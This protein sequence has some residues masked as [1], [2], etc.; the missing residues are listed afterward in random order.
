MAERRRSATALVRITWPVLLAGALAHGCVVQGRSSS[1][2][3][4]NGAGGAASGFAV[5]SSSTSGPKADVGGGDSGPSCGDGICDPDEDCQSC[6][7]D[8]ATG[9]ADADATALDSEELAFLVI[10]NDYRASYGTGPLATCTS[11]SRASQGHSED[12]RDHDYFEHDGLNGSKAWDRSCLACFEKGCGN[13]QTTMGENIA[14]GNA[15]APATFEQW[16]TSTTG[17]NEAMLNPDYNFIGIGRALGG[18]TYGSYWT[19]VFA[20][21]DEPSCYE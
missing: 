21:A 18:G 1:D 5:A 12:M 20:G 9:G 16:R 13:L 15:D 7:T 4:D 17:H 19:T 8:C 6:G 3:D 14:A 2:D 10:I 11:L